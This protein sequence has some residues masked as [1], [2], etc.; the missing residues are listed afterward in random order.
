MAL[1][2]VQDKTPVQ[3]SDALMTIFRELKSMHEQPQGNL[4][5]HTFQR[6]VSE[7]RG[8][9]VEVLKQ[10]TTLMMEEDKFL[11]LQALTQCGTPE[12]G[13]SMLSILKTMDSDAIEVDAAV[14]ALGMMHSPTA[15]LV[16]DILEITQ[17]KQSKP[18]MYALSNVVRR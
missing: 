13:S 5:A 16:K 18:I 9:E 11:A 1:E 3:T 6:L 8:L 15:L 10:A 14:Y 4:R 17:T 12:C 7:I 2:A